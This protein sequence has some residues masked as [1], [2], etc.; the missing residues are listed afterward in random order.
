MKS[1]GPHKISDV[2]SLNGVYRNSR[3]CIGSLRKEWLEK[4]IEDLKEFL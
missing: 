3:N 1:A 4:V 2:N